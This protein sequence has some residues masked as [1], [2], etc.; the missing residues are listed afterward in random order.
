L[1]SRDLSRKVKSAHRNRNEQGEYTAS[2]TAFGCYKNP[3][4]KHKLIV[5]EPA[6][7]VVR[8]IFALA[9]GGKSAA[10]IARILNERKTPTRLQ[11]QWERGINFKPKHNMGDYL[12][13]NTTVLAVIRNP[14]YKG[15]LIQ[16]RY[17]M[18]GFGDDKKI[19]K[20]DKSE[21]SVMENQALAIISRELFGW[22]K[23]L[24]LWQSRRVSRN[25]RKSVLICSNI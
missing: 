6:A 13:E 17:E 22:R 20:R 1:Y 23:R 3:T 19:V 12:W 2:F 11:R 5:D 25:R 18:I 7:E 14:I 15:T 8:E 10:E 21:W 16:N 4:D 24:L 9:A